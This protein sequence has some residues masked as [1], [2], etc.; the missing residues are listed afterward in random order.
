MSDKMRRR[1]AV[2]TQKLKQASRDIESA[3]E[4]IDAAARKKALSVD[5]EAAF[6]FFRKI[7]T[8]QVI[9]A[10]EVTEM[11]ELCVEAHSEYHDAI[12]LYRVMKGLMSAKGLLFAIGCAGAGA[13]YNLTELKEFF[14]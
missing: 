2:S 3:F 4:A 5:E 14:L 12:K 11:S 7:V 9:V 10:T 6:I 13:L 8:T 1:A